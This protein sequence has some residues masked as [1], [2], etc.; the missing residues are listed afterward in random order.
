MI[1]LGS[2]L[3][4]KDIISFLTVVG[5]LLAIYVIVHN[6]TNEAQNKDSKMVEN[7]TR[8][9]VKLDSYNRRI[10]SIEKTVEKSDAKLDDINNHMTRTDERINSLHEVVSDLKSRVSKLEGGR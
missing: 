9:E 6:R 3:S 2:Q 8:I 10:D 1:M 7:F 5:Q 4:L